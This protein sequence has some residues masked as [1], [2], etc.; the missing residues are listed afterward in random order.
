MVIQQKGQFR[1]LILRSSHVNHTMVK[2]IIEGEEVLVGTFLL[3]GHPIIIL[4]DSKALHDFISS[5]CA[6]RENLPLIVAKPSYMIHTPGSWIVANLVARE[7]PLELARHMFPAHLIVL[8]GQGID[9]ILG[10]SWM[11]LHKAILD[12]AK[13]LVYLNSLIYGKVVLHLSVVVHIK[14]YVHHTVAK[15]MEEIPVV[16]EFLD[17]FPDDLPGMPPERDI[18]FK[19]D[20]L[21]GTAPITKGPYKMIWEELV[22]LKI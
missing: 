3:S 7:V 11:K 18:E 15:S 20:L 4:F 2:D 12:I 10:M 14:T 22:E 16:R 13:W 8:D 1:D 17:V 6:K 9:I 19:I 21:H 5:A